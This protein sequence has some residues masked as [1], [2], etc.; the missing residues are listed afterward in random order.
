[1][2][3]ILK[4]KAE[5]QRLKDQ[6]AMKSFSIEDELNDIQII[7]DSK[8]LDAGCG[9]GVLCHFLEKKFPHAQIEGCDLDELGLAH[10]RRN[11]TSNRTNY[12]VHNLQSVPLSRRYDLIINRYVAHHLGSDGMRPVLK[13]LYNAINPGGKIC[14]IDIDGLMV[15]LATTNS[16]LMMK[17]S[18]LKNEFTGDLHVARVLPTLLHETGFKNISWEITTMD[19]KGEEK[20]EE[21]SLWMRRFESSLPFYIRV[22]GSEHEARIFFNEFS[23]EALKEHI[24]L[25]YNKF[26]IQ[27]QKD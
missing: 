27:A 26:V 21:V 13:N 12:F 19:F 22:F 24:P 9:S 10:A 18:Q 11:S 23:R 20:E 14:V 4:S 8:I 1:M 7:P 6:S 25:F 3:Y 5:A 2:S 17:I 15:N 16:T